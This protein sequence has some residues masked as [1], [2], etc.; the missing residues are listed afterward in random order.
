MNEYSPLPDIAE[1]FRLPGEPRL[2]PPDLSWDRRLADWH[3]MVSVRP[4]AE[5]PQVLAGERGEL[6]LRRV[7]GRHQSS[8][9]GH[10]FG[11]KRVPRGP[12][13][14]TG[15]R[16]EIDLI[17]V[18]PRRVAIVEVKH[19]SGTLWPEGE[20]WVYRRRSGEVQR[21]DS[22][23]EHNVNKVRALQ[24][25]LRGV[26]LDLPDAR[27]SQLVVFSHPRIDLDERLAH[28]PGV[29]TLYDL[30][31]SGA[32]LGRGVTTFEF[33]TARLIERC[34][35]PSTAERLTDGLYE[36][37]TPGFTAAVAEAV[38]QLRTWDVVRLHGG[39]ELIGDLLW[40]RIA[41]QRIDALAARRTARLRWW[42]GKVWAMVPLAG[43]T[44][45]GQVRGDL[46][47]GRALGV[48]DCIY[49]HEAG[50]PRPSVISLRYV[51][52][53]RTG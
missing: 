40:V 9:F 31:T 53:L 19:W 16:Y 49:F 35:K 6:S 21:F 27:F 10:V 29:V 13:H 15:G 5:L 28:H 37:L 12:G 8:R 46:L 23:V 50:Q 22:L 33:V 43:L 25:Y 38:R 2:R 30:Q 34:T 32:R 14:V 26:G 47:P 11:G 17:V 39:R 24:R 36:M 7:M 52:E 20:A 3:Q 48:D 45:F 18:T 4:H 51:D 42:R 41:G 1:E 44:P